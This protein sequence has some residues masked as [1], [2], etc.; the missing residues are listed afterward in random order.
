M[1][2]LDRLLD[3]T[4]TAFFSP[5]KVF[6][7]PPALSWPILPEMPRLKPIK[8]TPLLSEHNHHHALH[9][10]RTHTSRHIGRWDVRPEELESLG[11]SAAAALD[12]AVVGSCGLCSEYEGTIESCIAY[13]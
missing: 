4:P 8:L 12:K 3:G 13:L 5:A 9:V 2:Y 1:I 11:V 7:H 10:D 6:I